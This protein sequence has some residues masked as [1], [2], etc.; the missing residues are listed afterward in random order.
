YEDAGKPILPPVNELSVFA[1]LY[2]AKPDISTSIFM[3]RGDFSSPLYDLFTLQKRAIKFCDKNTK[4]SGCDIRL[5][6]NYKYGTLS[7]KL[8]DALDVMCRLPG[9]IDFY[10]KIDDALIMSGSA[11]EEVIKKMTITTSAQ[12]NG[13]EMQI[14]EPQ[15][16][17]KL[18]EEAPPSSRVKLSL[19]GHPGLQSPILPAVK[20]LSSLDSVYP[21]KPNISTTVFMFRSDFSSPYHDIFALHERAVKYCDKGTSVG[22]CDVKLPGN[23]KYETLSLKLLDTLDVMCRSTERTDYYVKIDDDL[24]MSN[25]MLEQIIR[26][27]STTDCQAAGRIALDYEFYWVE[28]QMYIFTKSILNRICKNLPDVTDV[29][30]NEDITFGYVLNTTDTNSFCD[31]N[32]PRHFW[33]KH[34]NDQRVEINYH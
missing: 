22:G 5:L 2:S 25:S 27:M 21:A 17:N 7:S 15:Y 33:H 24:I 19:F 18:K 14:G 31:I 4:A 8:L 23:Y 11:L 10:A 12:R 30:P 20:E 13:A 32:V 6:N 29:Y 26:K 9:R 1:S 16:P 3:F 28:G 34:Y